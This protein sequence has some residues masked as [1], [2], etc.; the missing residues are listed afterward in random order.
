MNGDLK[1]QRYDG[2][3]HSVSTTLFRLARAYSKIEHS[4]D[5]TLKGILH[6]LENSENIHQIQERAA[7]KGSTVFT[8]R[9]NSAKDSEG[10]GSVTLYDFS[11]ETKKRFKDTAGVSN[12]DLSI[13]THEMSH[14]LDEDNN[15]TAD[16]QYPNSASDPSEIRAVHIENKARNIDGL[17]PRTN[18]GGEKIDN[19][20]LNNPPNYILPGQK[21]RDEQKKSKINNNRV[22]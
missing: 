14:Q 17:P 18:Y 11:P 1:G 20:K 8:N 4:K 2:R 12:S 6:Q 9:E 16:D 13:V 21:I 10:K 3:K 5:N 19:E 7:G 15:N 22:Y